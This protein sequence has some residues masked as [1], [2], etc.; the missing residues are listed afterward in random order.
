MHVFPETPPGPE[1]VHRVAG[2]LFPL[3]IRLQYESAHVQAEGDVEISLG[4][5]IA[6]VGVVRAFG[7]LR[8]GV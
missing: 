6:R 7:A 3:E 5:E 8:A 4:P 1:F 2:V